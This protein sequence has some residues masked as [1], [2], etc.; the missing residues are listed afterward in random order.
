MILFCLAKH[1]YSKIMTACRNLL[2][3]A[4]SKE[5]TTVNG[6]GGPKKLTKMLPILLKWH[7]C[8]LQVASK[9]SLF[10]NLNIYTDQFD[11]NVPLKNLIVGGGRGRG[12]LPLLS[13]VSGHV[14]MSSPGFYSYDLS[15]V[16]HCFF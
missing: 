11:R 1:Q 15:S 5:S 14:Y 10:L 12:Q 8:T 3:K 16:N 13:P 9:Q 6:G 4:T 7:F 2:E